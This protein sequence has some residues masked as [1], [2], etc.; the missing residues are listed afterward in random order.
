MYIYS[1]YVG[2]I[3]DEYTVFDTLLNGWINK[4]DMMDRWDGWIDRYTE[5][6][7]MIDR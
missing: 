6:I 4:I 1:I 7:D 5:M 3:I 2:W